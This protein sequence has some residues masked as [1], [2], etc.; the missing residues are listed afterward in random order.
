MTDDQ[1]R[2]SVVQ[3][4][5]AGP[6]QRLMLLLGAGSTI[7][8]G[9][10]STDDITD[11]L[12]TR[13]NERFREVI[14][15][16]CEQRGSLGFNF[17]TVMAAMEALDGYVLDK[18]G[19]PVVGGEIGAFTALKPAYEDF[20][21]IVSPDTFSGLRQA[22]LSA[23]ATVVIGK[24]ESSPTT[25]LSVFMKH[26]RKHFDLTVVTLNYDDLIDRA[27]TWFDGF[28][29]SK[30]NNQ[31]EV[32]DHSA[33]RAGASSEPAVLLHLH[34]SVRFGRNPGL[35]RYVVKYRSA[36]EAQESLKPSDGPRLRGA[37]TIPMI[38]G[39]QKEQD[40]NY[41]AAPLGYYYNV[42]VNTA[43]NCPLWL[44]AGYGGNDAHVNQWIRESGWA[45]QGLARIAHIDLVGWPIILKLSGAGYTHWEPPAIKPYYGPQEGSFPPSGAILEDIIA[46]LLGGRAP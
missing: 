39:N 46:F 43:L 26:L 7:H 44:V 22:L 11:Y 6:R 12:C 24:T 41:Y 42:F 21:K 4:R 37:G 10:P 29:P 27:G 40:L 32:F 15:G 14:K 30:E 34:G 35:G 25:E 2:G 17:E 23:I 13:E 8:A 36:R 45:H 19:P 18:R 28:V 31:Y 5:S 1:L 16:L 38:S 9:A 20:L 33:F 3:E